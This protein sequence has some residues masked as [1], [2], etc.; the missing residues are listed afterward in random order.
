MSA[1][2][3]DLPSK[4]AETLVPCTQ[5]PALQRL[6]RE[7]G[8]LRREVSELRCDVGYWKSRHADMRKRNAQ[9]SEDLQQAQGQI[10]SLQDKLFGRKSEKSAR[11]DRSNDLFDPEE[12]PPAVKRRGAQPGHAGHDRRD[13]SQLPIEEEFVPLP[14]E[15]LACPICGKPAT[16]MSSTEDAELLEIEVRAHR[17]RIRRRR[18]RATCDR[19]LSRRMLTAP[20]PPKLIPKGNYGI[21]IWVHVL[22]DKYSSYRPT[23]RLLGQLKQYDL[24]LPAG[25]VND[26]LQRIEPMLRPVYEAFL[27]RNRRGE[28][29]QADETRWLVFVLLDGEKR[30]RLLVVGRPWRGHRD[31]SALFQPRPRGAGN[32]FWPTGFGSA[33][34]RS[35]LRLQ[36]HG[37]GEGGPDGAGVLPGACAARL[38]GRG[39]ELVG[40]DALG[41]LLVASHST[42]LSDQSG[43]SAVAAGLRD[44]SRTRCLAAFGGG[45]D[46]QPGRWKN[47]PIRSSA[48]HAA[49]FW[50]ASGS[51]GRDSCG[52][53][54]IHGFRW[55]TT[56]RNERDAAQP[57]HGRTSTARVPC[58]V[59]SWQRRCFR[60]WPRWPTGNSIRNGG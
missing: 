35:V 34:S 36:S 14:A 48:N 60:Y 43:T 4:T 32:A 40:T 46:A 23:E 50:K 2:L 13:Y 26:G 41:T 16:M 38:R 27:Q 21:S 37:A 22:L 17:R 49:K 33:G 57:W 19:D 1:T 54:M 28:F 45:G 42:R 10:R 6:V 9:L 3:L 59:A 47:S 25:T 15:S 7:L 58:G 20:P 12:V 29:H 18:Y 52:S 30:P 8:E 11:S 5:C 39:Q 56:P 55:T 44:V 53:S 51:T 24:D 31:L